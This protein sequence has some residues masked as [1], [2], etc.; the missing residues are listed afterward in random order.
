M[1]ADQ[2]VGGSGCEVSQDPHL[3]DVPEGRGCLRPGTA[4]AATTRG[5]MPDAFVLEPATHQI[6]GSYDNLRDLYLIT[7]R[8]D[9]L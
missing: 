3:R 5:G 1:P 9:R 6:D 2:M 7:Y 8:V 4:A